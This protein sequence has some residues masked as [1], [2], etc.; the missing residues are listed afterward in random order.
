MKLLF[1][2]TTFIVFFFFQKEDTYIRSTNIDKIKVTINLSDFTVLKLNIKKQNTKRYFML[3]N[4][5]I[6][7]DVTS[8]AKSNENI[9]SVLKVNTI[10]PALKFGEPLQIIYLVFI[11]SENGKI[12]YKGLDRE[13]LVD[14]YQKEF[15]RLMT[16]I[17]SNFEPAVL[18][19]KK[20]ASILKL[21]INYYEL[22]E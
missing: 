15:F 18:N 17:D 11:I 7:I 5:K 4:Q 22:F 8:E 14:D 1:F 20:V 13:F 6:F 12:I 3:N 9:D 19:N 21:K 16:L 10:R 2:V